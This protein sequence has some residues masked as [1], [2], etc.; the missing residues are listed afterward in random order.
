LRRFAPKAR[1]ELL[2]R[3]PVEGALWL[4]R[5]HATTRQWKASSRGGASR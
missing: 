3:P 2:D 5:A 4:A 1:V